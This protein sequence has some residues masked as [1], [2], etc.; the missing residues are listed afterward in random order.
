MNQTTGNISIG[1]KLYNIDTDRLEVTEYSVANIY[2][3]IESYGRSTVYAKLLKTPRN[4]VSEE[5]Y[6]DRKLSDVARMFL[7]RE[8]AEKEL[9]NYS[10]HN[11]G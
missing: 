9:A 7:T 6:Y 5:E 1:S 3:I 8:D 10:R 4:E 11:M 2:A